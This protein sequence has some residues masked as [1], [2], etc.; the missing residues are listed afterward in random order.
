MSI[1]DQQYVPEWLARRAADRPD[2]PAVIEAGGA[3]WTY[4]EL[5]HRASAVAHSL[6][7]AS[8]SRGDRVAALLTNGPPYVALVHGL[9]R[10]GAV[11]VPL[12]LRLAPPELAWQIALSGARILI[13]D[14]RTEGQAHSL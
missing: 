9:I 1:P 3:W 6:R 8:V 13:H 2:A 11:L 5:D 7:E 10:L 14:E 12:N 4:A